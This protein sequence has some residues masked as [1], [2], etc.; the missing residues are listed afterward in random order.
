MNTIIRH[1]RSS[2][3]LKCYTVLLILPIHPQGLER[4]VRVRRVIVGV[5]DLE[6]TAAVKSLKTYEFYGCLCV[7]FLSSQY[8][9]DA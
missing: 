1:L 9:L 3:A 8:V 7:S 5:K 6:R 4:D 2:H